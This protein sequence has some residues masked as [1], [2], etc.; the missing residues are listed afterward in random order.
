MLVLVPV[1][2][3]V[4]VPKCHMRSYQTN[5]LGGGKIRPDS[6]GLVVRGVPCTLQEIFHVF[7][8]MQFALKTVIQTPNSTGALY[9]NTL[10]DKVKI[11]IVISQCVK[12]VG[13]PFT[14]CTRCSKFCMSATT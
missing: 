9:P 6:S 3:T 1:P 13:M 2:V 10:S 5:A 11:R 4:P 7:G 12:Q 8:A 14:Q